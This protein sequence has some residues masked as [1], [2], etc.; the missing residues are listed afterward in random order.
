MWDAGFHDG[1]EEERLD[2]GWQDSD[3]L[4]DSQATWR[5]ELHLDAWPEHLAGPE[6]KLWKDEL[7]NGGEVP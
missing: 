4:D 6:Y 2:G 1:P 7:E 3:V 5:G